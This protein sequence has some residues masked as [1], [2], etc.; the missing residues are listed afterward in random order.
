MAG[1]IILLICMTLIAS[2]FS[3]QRPAEAGQ[4]ITAQEVVN[5]TDKGKYTS[6]EIKKYV[7]SLK[8]QQFSTTGRVH[9]VQSGKSG[10]KIVV[11]ADISG[12]KRF[13]VD[14]YTKTGDRFRKG[15]SVSCGGKIIKFNRFTYGGVGIEGSCS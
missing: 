1:R 4:N 15:A 6:A 2:A 7:G 10:Y 13:V 8:G 12:R 11:N 9:D 3:V 5:R 14:V